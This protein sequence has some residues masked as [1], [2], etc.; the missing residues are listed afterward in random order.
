[1]PDVEPTNSTMAFL[2]LNSAA[3]H[4]AGMA[5]PPVPPPAIRSVGRSRFDLSRSFTVLRYPVEDPH[6]GEAY[7]QAGASVAHEGERHTGEGEYDHGG[8]DVEDGLHGQHRGKAGGHAPGHH[9]GSVQ[10]DLQTG[11]RDK[12]ESGDHCYHPDQAEFL[13]DQGE[14]HVRAYLWYVGSLSPG[15]RAGTEEPPGLYG[16]HGL[17]YLVSGAVRSGPGVEKRHEPLAP[18]GLQQHH[19]RHGHEPHEAREDQNP[20]F[21]LGGPEH[22][23][24][25]GEQDHGRAEVRFDQDQSKQRPDHGQRLDGE[26]G[27]RRKAGDRAAQDEH[28]GELGELRGLRV[29]RAYI[30]PPPGTVDLT[31]DSWYEDQHEAEQDDQ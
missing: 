25:A 9:R 28:G 16:H 6:G 3:T 18:V 23:G 24:D 31:P 20:G 7:Q 8:P 12:P 26:P 29:H 27:T 14:D 30:E 13:P 5:C 15:A 1:M 11:Q 17:D 4:S 2:A 22:A 19:P 21:D 10:G